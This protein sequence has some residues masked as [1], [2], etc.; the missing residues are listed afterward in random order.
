MTFQETKKAPFEKEKKLSWVHTYM[1]WQSTRKLR[2]EPNC[3]FG[4]FVP[5][6]YS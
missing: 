5:L 6:K 1:Y 4:Q 3:A 2:K